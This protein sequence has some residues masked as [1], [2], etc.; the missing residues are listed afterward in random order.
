MNIYPILYLNSYKKISQTLSILPES[1]TIS[2]LF[3]KSPDI[4]PLYSTQYIPLKPKLLNACLST[5]NSTWH[6]I[7]FYQ[8]ISEI[9]KSFR[10]LLSVYLS[11]LS[12]QRIYTTINTT[13]I[14]PVIINKYSI[15]MNSAISFIISIFLYFSKTIHILNENPY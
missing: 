5:K 7:S 14:I 1:L 13:Q 8:K 9:I 10:S 2:L 15:P 11:R 12:I 4:T 3:F 6:L